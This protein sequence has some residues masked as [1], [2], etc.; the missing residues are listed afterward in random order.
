LV[1]VSFEL[2]RIIRP[3]A[4][5]PSDKAATIVRK[6]EQCDVSRDGVWSASV[7]LWQRY[8]RPWDGVAGGRGNAELVGSIAVIYDQPVKHEITIYK[9][10]MTDGAVKAGWTV[11]RLCDDALQFAGI[12]L[13]TCPR[14][15]LALPPPP[16]PFR[17]RALG[18]RAS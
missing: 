15:E 3:A 13:N 5:V 6:L 18:R 7:S 12:T 16:D 4:I 8:D 17:R 9:V 1:A 14:A 11:D 2:E 10:Q